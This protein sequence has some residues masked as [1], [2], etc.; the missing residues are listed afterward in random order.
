VFTS[1]FIPSVICGGK[2]VCRNIPAVFG[3]RDSRSGGVL[4]TEIIIRIIAVK[5]GFIYDKEKK[6]EVREMFGSRYKLSY[7][8]RRIIILCL[9]EMKNKLIRENRYTDAIDDLLVKFMK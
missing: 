2:H 6:K 1:F 7:D 3:C 4:L 9:I 8:E 5:P